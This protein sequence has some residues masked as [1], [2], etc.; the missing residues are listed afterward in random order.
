MPVRGAIL[1]AFVVSAAAAYDP[2]LNPQAIDEAIAIGQSPIES[3]RARFHAPYRVEV[4]RPPVDSLDL[5]TPFRRLELAAEERARLGL[6]RMRQVE[7][8]AA[9]AEHGGRLELFLELTFH[10]LNTYVGVPAYAITLAR[11]GVSEPPAAPSAVQRIP[12]F[13]PRLASGPFPTPYPIPLQ[14]PPAGQPLTGGIVLAAFDSARLDT[15]GRYEVVIEES[16]K[17]LGRVP[18]DLARLR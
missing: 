8:I 2:A 18:L 17:E 11:A 10:P 12:R 5:V 7:A 15:R 9:L 1:A 13:G 16:G 14:L 6:A 4:N 3:V